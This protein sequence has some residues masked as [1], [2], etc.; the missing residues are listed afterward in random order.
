[1][2]GGGVA[3]EP[4]TDPPPAPPP[5]PDTGSES[6]DGDDT[7]SSGPADD[8]ASSNTD[9]DGG[10][11][12]D[13]GGE[14]SGIVIEGTG[15]NRDDVAYNLTASDQSGAPF[16]LHDKY[17]SKIALVVGNLDVGTTA[18]TLNNLNG[19]AAGHPDVSFIALI[20]RDALG[21]KCDQTCAASVQSTYGFSPVLWETASAMPQ[22]NAFVQS[23]NTRTYLIGSSMVIDWTKNGTANGSQ[24]DGRLDDLE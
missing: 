18:D 8:T 15:Y 11:P 21:V 1:M 2:G 4:D 19:I 17:G 6:S 23:Q 3:V 14:D 12:P 13:D 22:F 24:V 16:S 10:V 20:G 5:D 9:A 7:A